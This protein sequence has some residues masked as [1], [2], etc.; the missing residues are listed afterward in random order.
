MI[1]RASVQD[2]LEM[3]RGLGF[4]LCGAGPKLIDLVTFLEQKRASHISV[5]LA[6]E[7]AQR[8][9][10]V[11]PTEWAHRLSLVRGFARLLS[12]RNRSADPNSTD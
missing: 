7:W 4:N 9:R 5:E 8:P 10:S 11:L 2:Y 12:K 6:L 3:R 1:L